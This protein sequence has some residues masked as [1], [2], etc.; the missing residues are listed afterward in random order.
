MLTDEADHPVGSSP[1]E[2]SD[3]HEAEPPPK[4]D[5]GLYIPS[6]LKEAIP[7]NP[8]LQVKVAH[9]L[10]VQE[11]NSRRCFTCNWPSH[12]AW[13]HQEWE[14]KNGIRPL[15]SKQTG[16]REGQTKTPSARVARASHRVERVPYLNPDAFPGLL[17][18]RIGA[19]L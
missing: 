4:E 7:D 8:V 2:D 1:Y 17:A 3:P 13:D 12:L 14:E 11:M 15:H 18:P 16:L 5:D 10:R 9:T 19:R 6:Y